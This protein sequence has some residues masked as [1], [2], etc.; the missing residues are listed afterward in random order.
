MLRWSRQHQRDEETQGQ[1]F[2]LKL[3]LSIE[4]ATAR[5][6]VKILLS[7]FILDGW[8]KPV[9]IFGNQGSF[10]CIRFLNN[11]TFYCP[12][13]KEVKKY[14]VSGIDQAN[15]KPLWLSQL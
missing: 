9:A 1:L 4:Q 8:F 14:L 3:R 10:L 7:F 13:A 2:F 6:K 11:L 5:Q 12:E 15:F